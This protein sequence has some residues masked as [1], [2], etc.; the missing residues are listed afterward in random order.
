LF[1]IS[2]GSVRRNSIRLLS[3]TSSSVILLGC[4]SDGLATLVYVKQKGRWSM[5]AGANVDIVAAVQQ[6]DPVKQMPK[7]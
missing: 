3:L 5:T 4:S 2:I 1:A 6:F 7:N